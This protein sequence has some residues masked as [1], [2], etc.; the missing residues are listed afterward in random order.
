MTFSAPFKLN[1]D[2]TARPQWQPNISVSNA[3]TLLATWY[4]AR[5]SASC[6]SGNPGVPCYR[7][8]SRK[9]T[10]NGVTWTIDDAFSDVVSPLPAQPDPG[11]NATYAGDY[12][13]GSAIITKHVTSWVDGRVAVNSASQQDAFTDSEPVGFAVATTNP[14][15]NGFINTQPVDFVINLTDPV[16]PSAVQ[17]TDL[18]V[19]G[20]PADSFALSNNNGTITFSFNTSP[21]TQQGLQT[22]HILA[23][24]LLRASDGR[25]NLDFACT[26][27]YASVQLQVTATVPAVGGTFSPAAPQTYQYDVNWNI[28]VDPSSVQASDLSLSG[29]QGATVSSVA[30]INN[31]MTTSFMINVPSGGSLTTSVA[32]GAITDAFG[33]PNAPFTGNYAVEG[34]QYIITNGT[35]P[36]V[37]GTTDTGN[38]CDDCDTPVSLPFP[39]QLYGHTYTTVNVNSN[40]RMDFVTANE[41]NGH[42]T[43]CLPAPPNQGPYDYTIFPLWHDMSTEVGVGGCTT[44]AN[45]CGIFTSVTGTAPHRV[46]NIEWH[47]LRFYD[48]SPVNFEARLFENDLNQRFDIIYGPGTTITTSDTAGVQGPPGSVTQDFCNST[49]PQNASRSYAQPFCGTPS[50]TPTA[51]ATPTPTPCAPAAA[52]AAQSATSINFVSFTANWSSVSGATGYRL[53]VSLSSAFTTYVPGYQNL[54]VG[55]RIKYDVTGLSANTTYYYRV[56]AYNG[57][58]TSPNSSTKS[59]R[60]M[61]CTLKAPSIA[62]AANVTF[63]SFSANWVGVSGATDYRLDV[64]TSSSFTSYV[65]GYQDLH[66]GNVITYPVT[67]LNPSTTYYY[68]VRAYNGCSASSNSSSKSVLDPALHTCGSQRRE[69]KQCDF[70]QL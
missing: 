13:Y 1:T 61:A 16:N 6:S 65:P 12:D 14:A 25:P 50:P 57:C 20:T 34:C 32:P 8:W 63:S 54:N 19:N 35:D 31:A 48:Q 56:R 68:R 70:Q 3:G 42:N 52:P 45:G 17:A 5:E 27:N 15:C 66:V 53:D 4:D 47:A 41:P 59:L 7:M 51:T 55:N 36:I 2:A 26:F 28:P 38:H 21:I 40:G 10:D 33:N 64:S 37:P 39:F 29:V 18:T 9:S 11:I 22:M 46:F 49:P 60:T 30:V 62:S 69:R 23:G 43:A 44:W 58:T 67:G 24:A